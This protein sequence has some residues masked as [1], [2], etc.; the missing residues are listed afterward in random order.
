MNDLRKWL[1]FVPDRLVEE[2]EGDLMQTY[3]RELVRHGPRK[4][5][6]R[7]IWNTMRFFRPSIILR[8]SFK[9]FHQTNFP[10]MI[11]NYFK[12]LLRHMARHKVNAF[13]NVLGLTT[14]ITFA[15]VIGVFVWSEMQVNQQLKD[16]D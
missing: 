11:A 4:A 14:G 2:I 8:N 9:V 13:V 1:F 16:V 5:K 12:V 7:L 6:I 10:A 3:E 15:L